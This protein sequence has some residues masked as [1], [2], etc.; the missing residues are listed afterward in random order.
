[1]TAGF[2]VYRDAFD[3]PFTHVGLGR[4][5]SYWDQTPYE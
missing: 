3:H 2:S 5:Q 4:F 1:V